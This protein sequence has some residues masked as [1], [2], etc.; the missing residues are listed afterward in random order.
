[1]SDYG[2]FAYL[3]STEA[4]LSQV[5]LTLV[6]YVGPLPLKQVDNDLLSLTVGI[7]VSPKNGYN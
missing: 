7:R 1:M 2:V 4:F 6:C 5:P 3:D